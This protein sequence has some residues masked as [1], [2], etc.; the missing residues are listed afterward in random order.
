MT[1]KYPK[2]LT[3][4]RTVW[5]DTSGTS[6]TD[7]NLFGNY[8]P[9]ALSRIYIE[10]KTPRTKYC[11]DFF[12]ISEF[13]L[14]KRI[15]N[16]KIKTGK[17]INLLKENPDAQS[18]K[19]E[20]EE[21]KIMSHVRSNRSMAYTFARE[22]LWLFNGW[23][24]RE[25][26]HYIDNNN[27]DVVFIYGSPLILMNR[28]QNFV[29]KRVKKPAAYYFMD[30]VY[31]Y[32]SVKGGGISKYIYKFFLR[33]SVRRVI[34]Q[35]QEFFVVSPKMKREYDAI[36]NF[37]SKILTKG[38]D[39]TALEFK[40]NAIN[41]P[42]KIVYL[43]Q[44]IYG[45]VYSLVAMAQTL[46]K[47]NEDDIKAELY[48]YTGN[49]ISDEM[50]DQ[51][52][53]SSSHIM[54]LVPYEQVQQI[55]AEVD[56]VVFAE[57]LNEKHKNV[58]RLSFSTKITDYLSAGKC[59]FAIGPHDSAPIEYLRDS[60]VAVVAISREEIQK[61][62]SDLILNPEMINT[63]A[64]KSFQLGKQNHDLVEM[65]SRLYN[66]FSELALNPHFKKY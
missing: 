22:I 15:W 43:G 42:L 4:T 66:T 12:Q 55:M 62:L 2:V 10:T 47:F 18:G 65:N 23:K 30:D 11:Y 48:I 50:R 19:F 49:F 20:K 8:S 26:K 53:H 35:C 54:P 6:S 51:L 32:Q 21:Q 52:E 3:V 56:V 28:L 16:K 57:S 34:K 64:K 7:S 60:E 33:W 17:E 61:K 63:Y 1:P 27:P 44:I 14:I 29:L 9:E 59:I 40:P 13:A 25:L 37:N 39:F 5:D 58:A 38:I 31:T 36:F 41:K 45:R 24:S 46:K